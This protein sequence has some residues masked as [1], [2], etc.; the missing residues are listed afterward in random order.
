VFASAVLVAL[1]LAGVPLEHLSVYDGSWTE[2]AQRA[3]DR[4]ERTT[5]TTSA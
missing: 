4:I 3:P 1:R 5:S 2:Y